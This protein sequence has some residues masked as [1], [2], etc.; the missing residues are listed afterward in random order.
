MRIGIYDPYLDDLGGGEKYM[1]TIASCLSKQHEVTIFWNNKDDVTACQNRF[2]LSL[3]KVKLHKNIFAAQVSFLERITTAWKYDAI[4]ILSDGS[5]PFIPPTKLY[6]HIQQPL[7]KDQRSKIKD[8]IKM[9][10]ITAIFYNSHFTK[11]YNDPLFPG[12]RSEVI[13]PPVTLDLGFKVEDIRKENWIMHVGRFRAG[14][15]ESGDYKKQGFMVGAFKEMVDQGLKGWTFH[16]ASSVRKDDE[17]KFKLLKNNAKGYP[18]V[19]HVNKTQQ[20]LFDLY[21]KAKIYWH[22][23]GYGEDVQK[24]PELAEHFGMTTVEAMG[25]GVVPVVINSG[26]QAEIVTNNVNGLLWKTKEELINQTY[27]VISDHKLWEHLSKKAQI[28]SHDF[29]ADAFY[30][31]VEKLIAQ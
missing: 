4:V 15:I 12:V 17:G 31:K 30:A 19:F 6:L 1:M 22:A 7:A 27:K 28:R 18:I 21:K 23:S 2:H 29:S 9:R 25:F 10:Q 26:G 16:L 14:N 24:H 13:Y 8:R 11:G 5:I 3:G 20:E